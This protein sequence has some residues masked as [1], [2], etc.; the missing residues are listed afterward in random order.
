M[1]ELMLLEPVELTD[2]ELDAVAAG[3]NTQHG[4]GLVNV[5]VQVGDLTVTDVA[6]HNNI[7][8]TNFL[9]GNTVNVPIG[10]VIAARNGAVGVGL[11]NKFA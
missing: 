8:L 5:G 1:S 3:Q 2:A 7:T 10:V 6:S 11:L 4:I 9:N